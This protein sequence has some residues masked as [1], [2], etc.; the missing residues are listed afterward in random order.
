MPDA[1][2]AE[3]VAAVG[4]VAELAEGAT[5][6][7]EEPQAAVKTTAPPR[8]ATLRNRVVIMICL[9]LSCRVC[10]NQPPRPGSRGA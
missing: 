1:L 5:G 4:G 7:L 8:A 3:S 10:S 6:E 2:E 9:T